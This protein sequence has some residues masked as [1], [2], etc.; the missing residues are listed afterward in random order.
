VQFT[1]SEFSAFENESE[2]IITLEISNLALTE[3][4]VIVLTLPNTADGK[5]RLLKQWQ[6]I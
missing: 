3:F 4:S 6:S 5:Y 2:V 1:Q